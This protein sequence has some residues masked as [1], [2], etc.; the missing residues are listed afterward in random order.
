MSRLPSPSIALQYR[1]R[2][3]PINAFRLKNAVFRSFSRATDSTAVALEERRVVPAFPVPLP[4]TPETFETAGGILL[5]VRG[6]ATRRADVIE[7]GALGPHFGG[8]S[9]AGG[10]DL[11]SR[12]PSASP[13]ELGA[14]RGARP[15]RRRLARPK[16]SARS[17]GHKPGVLSDGIVPTERGRQGHASAKAEAATVQSGCESRLR[18]PG[19]FARTARST[20][21][22]WGLSFFARRGNRVRRPALGDRG[23]TPRPGRAQP[24]EA[25]SH[26]RLPVRPAGD[27]A[28]VRRARR[29][30]YPSASAFC[31]GKRRESAVTMPG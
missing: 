1:K 22:A 19:L 14:S 7:T 4:G 5:E 20:Q 31:S 23:Q 11:I 21:L 28:E 6:P 13:V 3:E 26:K 12:Q 30:G 24:R 8:L 16:P 27:G 10:T 9:P 15:V 29:E 25:R 2:L 18:G 17:A